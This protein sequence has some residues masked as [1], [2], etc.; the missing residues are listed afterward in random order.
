MVTISNETDRTY[1]FKLADD[2]VYSLSFEAR[3]AS[4]RRLELSDAYKVAMSKSEPVFYRELAIK[5][6]IGRAHV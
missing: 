6:E 2:R 5:P 4:N 3:T 1:R